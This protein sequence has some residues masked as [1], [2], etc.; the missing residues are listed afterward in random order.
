MSS[1]ATGG[2]TLGRAGDEAS[3]SV[4]L[5][6]EGVLPI[7]GV[8]GSTGETI[9]IDAAPSLREAD[10]SFMADVVRWTALYMPLIMVEEDLTKLKEAYRI[11]ADIEL[12]LSRPNE[13]ACFPKRKC[14]ALH[15]NA[16]VSG[17]RLPMHPMFRRIL[18][19]YGLALTQVVPNGWS[20]IV[21]D[22]YL[23]FR[24]SFSMEMPLH[25]YQTVYQLKKLPKK[26][27]REEEAVWYYFCP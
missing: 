25:V 17:M 19:A 3:H 18:G 8:D 9:P 1:S 26:K 20:Q 22:M 27:G 4:S 10:D 11:S 24:H 23:W 7:R 16:F 6:M 12:M 5:S 14:T 21:G 2:D 15:L 13:R